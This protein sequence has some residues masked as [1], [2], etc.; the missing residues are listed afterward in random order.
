MLLSRIDLSTAPDIN[1]PVT[2]Q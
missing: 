2:P 1:L